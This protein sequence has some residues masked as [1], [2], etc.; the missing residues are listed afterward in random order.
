MLGLRAKMLRLT[1][2]LT[3]VISLNSALAFSGA[4]VPWITYEAEDMTYTGALQGPSYSPNVVASESSGRRCVRLS[5]TGQYAQFT[6]AS[7]ANAI[8]VRYSVPDTSGGGGADYTLSLYKNG[9]FVGK[10][11]VTSKY[12]WLYGSYPFTNTPSSGT[13]RNF[14]DEVRTNGVSISSNDVVKVQK[15]AGDTASYYDI[16]LVDLENVPAAISQPLGFAS[17]T[18]YGAVG[19]GVSDDT[20]AFNN[21]IIGN[22]NVWIPPGNYKITGTINCT[23]GKTIRGAGMWYSTLVGDPS[24]Y[25]TPSRRIILFGN[26]SNI[27]LSDF[28]IVGK[29]NYRSDGEA[30]DGLG[31]GGRFDGG[32]VISNIWVEHTKTGGWIINSSNLTVNSCRFRNTIADGINFSVG[33]RSCVLT[34]CTARGTGD[35][36]FAVWPANYLTPVY[37]PGLNVITHCTA[38]TSWLAQ[39]AAIYGGESNR[40]EDSLFQDIPYGCGILFSTTFPVSHGFSGTTVAQRCDVNRCGGTRAGVQ[41]YMQNSGISGLNLN[42]L[43]ISNSAGHGLSIVHGAGGGLANAI[44]YNSTIPNYGLAG[45]GYHGMWAASSAVGSLTVSNCTIAEYQ[46]DAPNFSFNFVT[47][48]IPVT[49]QTSPTGR[50]FTVDGNNYTTTQVFNWT[51]SSSHTIATTS[52]QSGG[53]GTQ[54]VWSSWSDSGA[55]SHTVAPSSTTT[56]TANFTT[57]YYLTMNAGPGGSVSPVSDWY[58]SGTNVDISATVWNGYTF[59]NWAGTGGGSYSGT[60][61]PASGTI[62]GPITQTASFNLLAQILGITIGGDG[63]LT[64]SY[65]TIPGHTY[66]VETTTN[67]SSSAWTTIPGSTT[68]AAESIIIFIDPNAVGDPQRFYRVASP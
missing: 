47:T 50:S 53:A 55:I 65:A 37:T 49:V 2:M 39:G 24:L 29:L 60:N 22:T 16:D 56:Y 14:Y 3:L 23:S 48:T 12:S 25:G 57:Q 67:L 66:H 42:N 35:D 15:D 52:P 18:N 21:C 63:S 62:N 33:M 9:A 20:S 36:G 45:G 44:L 8:V 51:P 61:N 28:A 32:S 58:D 19:N 64:I 41:I 6:A 68:N 40:I 43:S 27:K 17:V 5:A 26:G 7:A 4:T 11:A 38:Q 59:G 34:N 31:G 54:Y 10:L 46:D 30:N 1:L 13:P